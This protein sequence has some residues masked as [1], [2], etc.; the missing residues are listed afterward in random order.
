M[1]LR[2]GVGPEWE[3]YPADQPLMA[4][5]GLPLHHVPGIVEWDDLGKP[6]MADRMGQ[7]MQSRMG[8]G[9]VPMN[10]AATSLAANAWLYDGDAKYADWIT[11]Y[12]DGWVERANDNSGIVPDN[13]DPDGVSGGMQDG[14]WYG[15]HYGW[16]WPHGIASIGMGTL[17]AGQNAA[18]VTGDDSYFDLTRVP[19]DLVIDNAV[20]EEPVADQPLSLR[21]SWMARMGNKTTGLYED[22]KPGMLVPMR[23]GQDGWFDY[24]PMLN[25]F[26]TWLW[27]WTM[28]DQ[29]TQRLE[30]VLE[31]GIV[32]PTV[33]AEFR[34][35][36]EAGH[37]A[38]WVSYLWGANP[39][40]PE[41]ALTMALGQVNHRLDL[42]DLF[43]F[44][45]QKSHIH[46]WQG[47]N[48]VVT[49]V[50]TQL[51]TGAPPALYNGGLQHARV[52][53]YDRAAGRPGLPPEVSALVSKITPD[54]V[55]L[56]LVNLGVRRGASVV[57][58]AGAFGEDRI[59]EVEATVIDEGDYP[60]KIIDFATPEVRTKTTR[61]AVSTNR[62][63]V[64]LPA[65][66]KITL[67]LT[68]TPKAYPARHQLNP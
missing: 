22:E 27:W 18:L 38:P 12:V 58:Q 16:T 3:T 13:V 17:I 46:Y 23:Y 40:Y 49:E 19:L 42:M 48:P 36:E 6:G 67:T 54:S 10:L 37:E 43:P 51:T 21:G 41:R 65:R 2:P 32:D 1:G 4:Q 50:L 52:R 7:A 15:G 8:N 26:P 29:D 39:D 56:E 24:G 62:I 30:R 64:E 14:R 5:Y 47:V 60:G 20:I 28:N 34:D 44:D 57:V 9:D 53:Y 63:E 61:R 55:T 59:D 33:V 68:L 31:E 11:R 35:K 25:A 45:P 66:K